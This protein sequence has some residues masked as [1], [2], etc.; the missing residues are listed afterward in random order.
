M[1]YRNVSE[2]GYTHYTYKDEGEE[3]VD[4]Q[5]TNQE[6]E[7]DD[8][9]DST[10]ARPMKSLYLHPQLPGRSGPFSSRHLELELGW[11]PCTC[12]DNLAHPEIRQPSLEIGKELTS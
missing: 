8:A 10:L 6:H 5:C 9:P 3:S 1:L 4:S 12:T 11:Q 2:K 7:A